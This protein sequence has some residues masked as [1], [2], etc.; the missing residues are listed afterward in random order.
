MNF[1]IMIGHMKWKKIIE[2]LHGVVQQRNIII[3]LRVDF[4]GTN[5]LV[6]NCMGIQTVQTKPR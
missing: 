4:V 2:T 5:V 1:V 3:I 6:R